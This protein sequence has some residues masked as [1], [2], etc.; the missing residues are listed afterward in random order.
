MRKLLSLL[1]GLALTLVASQSG[2]AI[3]GLVGGLSISVAGL[4]PITFYGGGG[5]LVNGSGGGGHLDSLSLAGGTFAGTAFL[6][7]TD[8]AASPISALQAS[9]TNGSGAFFG[10]PGSTSGVFGGIMPVQGQA[11]VC[12]YTPLCN[13]VNLVVPFTQTGQGIG[14]G[15]TVYAPGVIGFTV[16]GAPWTINTAAA[17]SGPITTTASNPDVVGTVMGFA[18]GPLSGGLSSA[19]ANSGV[20]QLVTPAQVF[21]NIGPSGKL[22]VFGILTLHFVPEPGTLLLLGSGVAGLALIGRK[23]MSR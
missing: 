18:H 23:R 6:A 21:T 9:G 15:G 22:P 2:A 11:I 16:V 5:A 8:P 17:V 13:F 19:A 1:A 4:N 14:V 20:V 3:L 10:P 12:L 7:V